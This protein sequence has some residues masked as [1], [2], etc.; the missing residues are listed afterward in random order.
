MSGDTV[1]P[2]HLLE[3]VQASWATGYVTNPPVPMA[4]HVLPGSILRTRSSHLL[5][6]RDALCT[7]GKDVSG[8]SIQLYPS[9][10]CDAGA[11]CCY[12]VGHRRF[13]YLLCYLLCF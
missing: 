1:G 3:C 13:L 8:E 5:A 4:A 10:R 11:A 12:R 6:G 9:A 2:A 7:R